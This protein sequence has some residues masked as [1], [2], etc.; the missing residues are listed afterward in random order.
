M[1]Y[2]AKKNW[3]YDDVV[4]EQDLNRIERGIEENQ[5]SIE[6]HLAEDVKHISGTERADWNSKASGTHTHTIVQVTGLQNEL[7]KKVDDSM[8]NVP[9]GFVG[10]DGSGKLPNDRMPTDTNFE[11][12]LLRIINPW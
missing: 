9:N 4:T 5:Q 2:Q 11:L 8:R 3:Q 6:T 10:L 12:E 1:A 7:D